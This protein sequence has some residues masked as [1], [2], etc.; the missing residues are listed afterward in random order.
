MFKKKRSKHHTVN[1]DKPVYENEVIIDNKELS[2]ESTDPYYHEMVR[3]A[4]L[5]QAFHHSLI[6]NE[7]DN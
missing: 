5:L 2:A 7:P 6:V 1:T 3:T 4:S